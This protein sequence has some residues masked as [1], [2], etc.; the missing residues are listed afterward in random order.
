MRFNKRTRRRIRNNIYRVVVGAAGGG[1]THL[2][3][4]NIPESNKKEFDIFFWYQV[5]F[6]LIETDFYLFLFLL[7]PLDVEGGNARMLG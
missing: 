2:L 6:H 3:S 7:V 5:L 4:P 1:L